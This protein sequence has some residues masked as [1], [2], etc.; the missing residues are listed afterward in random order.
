MIKE[1][2]KMD[3]SVYKYVLEKTREEKDAEIIETAEAIVSGLT[4]EHD[5]TYAEALETLELGKAMLK[6]KCVLKPRGDNQE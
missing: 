3:M 2:R 6:S 4:K 5:F 1:L